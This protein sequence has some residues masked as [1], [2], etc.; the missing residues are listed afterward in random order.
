[1][2]ITRV[3]KLSGIKRTID[4][5][6]T[7]NQYNAWRSGVKIQDAMPNLNTAEREFIISGVTDEEWNNAFGEDL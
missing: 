4:L 7:E 3:S 6:V 2:E 5:N 1:M